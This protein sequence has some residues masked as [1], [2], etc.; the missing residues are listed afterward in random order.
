MVNF[1]V[2]FANIPSIVPMSNVAIKNNMNFKKYNKGF[3]GITASYIT[4]EI[5]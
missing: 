1:E 3:P 2:D 4:G 5:K